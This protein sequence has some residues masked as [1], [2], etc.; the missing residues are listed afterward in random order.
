MTTTMSKQSQKRVKLT[1]LAKKNDGI[2]NSE[3]SFLDENVQVLL[4][5]EYHGTN[6]GGWQRQGPANSI[7]YPSV[8]GTL[9]EAATEACQSF[10]ADYEQQPSAGTDNNILHA[11][12]CILIPTTEKGDCS[13][14]MAGTSGRTDRAVHAL[15]HHCLLRLPFSTT[16]LQSPTSSGL[17]KFLI[18]TSTVPSQSQDDP[19]QVPAVTLSPF[20]T[21]LNDKYLPPDIHVLACQILSKPQRKNLKFG[22]KRYYYIIQQCPSSNNIPLPAWNDYTLY[23]K[24]ALNVGRMRQGLQHMIGTHDF[25]PLSRQKGKGNTVRTLYDAKLTVV[26]PPFSDII[27][28]F[29]RAYQTNK[30]IK[31]KE[32][33]KNNIKTDGFEKRPLDGTSG[34]KCPPTGSPFL[35]PHYGGLTH[36]G[37][38][39]FPRP[40]DCKLLCIEFNG[41]GFLRHQVRHMVSVLVKI[42]QGAWDPNFV[43]RLLEGGDTQPLKGLAPSPGRGLWKSKVWIGDAGMVENDNSSSDD[44]RILLGDIIAER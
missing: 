15:E 18:G 6:Y 8:Q 14:V 17:A 16:L 19:A 37:N 30:T 3:A 36:D 7:V 12:T 33:K 32:R 4:T 42:G 13:V 22:R 27:P 11:S 35:P 28:W 10:V 21:A 1:N 31:K 38:T 41:C 9:E 25:L 5:L 44:S 2:G 34:M 24:K 26:A 23:V 39:H 40:E 29:A 43:H 20:L